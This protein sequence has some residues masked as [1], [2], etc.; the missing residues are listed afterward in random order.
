LR[1]IRKRYTKYFE[2]KFDDPEFEPEISVA[3][4]HFAQLTG[5]VPPEKY[6]DIHRLPKS[7]SILFY[8]LVQESLAPLSIIHGYGGYKTEKGLRDGFIDIIYEE[9]EQNTQEEPV[10]GLGVPSLPSLITTNNFSIVKG[11]G[12]PFISATTNH[13]WV[14]LMSTRSNAARIMLEVIWSKISI[15]FNTAMPWGEYYQRENVKTLLLAVPAE[16]IDRAGWQYFSFEVSERNLKN[17]ETFIKWAPIKVSL[18]IVDAFNLMLMYGGI[19]EQEAMEY[20]AKKHDIKVR[21]LESQFTSTMLFIK[22]NGWIRPIGK[23]VK[24]LTNE[25]ETGYMSSDNEK[26]DQ[27]CGENERE[28][29]YVVL[30]FM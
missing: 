30:L 8:T 14:V 6:S 22:D 27:W 7:Q 5:K 9:A 4:K 26:F 21:D 24:L 23:C 20:I 19:L 25:D 28:Q 13:E 12:L 16:V 3:Q 15:Y 18:E 10:E 11:N 1:K 29:S 17:R 2:S